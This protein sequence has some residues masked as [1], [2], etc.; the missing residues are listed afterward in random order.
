MVTHS[1]WDCVE[2]ALTNIQNVSKRRHYGTLGSHYGPLQFRRYYQAWRCS[3]RRSPTSRRSLPPSPPSHRH[4]VPTRTMKWL[5][6]YMRTLASVLV[7][8]TRHPGSACSYLF[9]SGRSRSPHIS[10]PPHSHSC[11]CGYHYAATT[12][13][14]ND[15]STSDG[16]P[17]K[18]SRL[19]NTNLHVIPLIIVPC[20]F[21]IN[22]LLLRE[23]NQGAR[24]VT[25]TPRAKIESFLI[26]NR[27]SNFW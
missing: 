1:F 25:A 24:K 27:Y 4:H 21:D 2:G 23:V 3:W 13:P 11:P 20:L 22:F 7:C 10:F 9:V 14:S 19:T 6:A 8:A 5:V 16:R 15:P 18:R 12:R 17:S 26:L